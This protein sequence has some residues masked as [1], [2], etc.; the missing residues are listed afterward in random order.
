[1]IVLCS[2]L[3]NPSCQGLNLSC[4]IFCS[5][6]CRDLRFLSMKNLQDSCNRNSMKLRTYQNRNSTQQALVE[7]VIS[8]SG[9]VMLQ[10][11]HA[12]VRNLRAGDHGT[13]CANVNTKIVSHMK[14]RSCRRGLPRSPGFF[15]GV[16]SD[17]GLELLGIRS[18]AIAS[19]S[20][21]CS[22]SINVTWYASNIR[23][24]VF[25]KAMESDIRSC[26]IWRI[27]SS[28]P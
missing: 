21:R 4:Q 19:W 27:L 5:F 7:L 22:F 24:Q 1:M 23:E 12:A 13:K 10:F 2:S 14:S 6:D 25:Q 26:A 18:I 11:T 28:S 20:S 9:T 8:F 3:N 16:A 15:R 17:A